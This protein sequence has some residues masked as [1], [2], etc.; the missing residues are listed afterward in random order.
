MKLD[1]LLF[2]LDKR[3]N[4]LL[5]GKHG[6]G[7]TAIILQA[8]EKAGLRYAYFS[9]STMD[10]FIDF[11]GVPIKVDTADGSYIELIRPKHIAEGDIQAIFIDEFNRTHKKIRNAVMELIQ[12]KTINKAPISSD[13]RVIWAA[14]NP[15][16]GEDNTYDTDRLDPA[17]RDRF[18]IQV[19]VPY[20]CDYDYFAS[21]YD[22]VT[23]KSA[24]Q[25]WNDLPA[26]EKD[27]VSPR[28]LDYA[29]KIWK[30]GGDI[31]DSL[32]STCNPSRLVNI[33]NVGP[34]EIKL[35]SL[36][37]NAEEARKFLANENNYSYAIKTII[38]NA[39]F[40]SAFIPLLPKEKI[41]TLYVQEPKVKQHM[42]ADIKSH[43][44][45]SAFVK[46]L[47]EIASA[48]Q[49][50]PIAQQ[51][52]DELDKVGVVATPKEINVYFARNVK[53]DKT[54]IDALMSEQTTQTYHRMVLYKKLAQNIGEN[55]AS[56]AAK[57]VINVINKLSAA[58]PSTIDRD[59]PN[60]Y[61]IGNYAILCLLK[62]GMDIKEVE[63]YVNSMRKF[64]RRRSDKGC[65][66]V[67]DISRY[68]KAQAQPQNVIKSV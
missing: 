40:M 43:K 42:L 34:A 2:W 8:F 25:W 26:A 48:N 57:S 44:V 39:R 11:C 30:D 58:Q 7:K 24:I 62:N 33:L 49:N 15:D 1:K 35:N 56:D 66:T 36:L 50:Q 61:G 38:S 68:L 9:G 18:H 16:S 5:E 64:R 13:L 27:K 37:G 46:P 31:R 22:E 32:P 67:T 41:N 23:A 60:L 4:V 54:V 29:V 63:K 6:V 17:Q 10:P 14:V 55:M 52:R 53:T 20:T 19:T 12:F 47:M 51:I 28:R 59:M 65:P 21:T 3:Y 45:S